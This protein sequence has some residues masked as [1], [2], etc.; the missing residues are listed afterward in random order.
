MT[1][2]MWGFFAL[3]WS[4]DQRLLGGPRR[5]CAVIQG[6]PGSSHASEA[7][8][9]KRSERIAPAGEGGQETEGSCFWDE[10]VSFV[11]DLA[12]AIVPTS[13]RPRY[14]RRL[15]VDFLVPLGS[16][17]GYTTW[18]TPFWRAGVVSA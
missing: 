1:W 15:D 9:G 14:L 4:S 18:Y 7:A 17:D 6:G 8:G 16:P 10:A 11:A 13:A 2:V 5:R 3:S 12:W